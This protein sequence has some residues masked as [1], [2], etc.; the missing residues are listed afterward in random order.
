MRHEAAEAKICRCERPASAAAP[1]FPFVA[2]VCSEC[3]GLRPAGRRADPRE[4]TREIEAEE[5]TLP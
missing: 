2:K 3:G 4:L 1:C 5:S